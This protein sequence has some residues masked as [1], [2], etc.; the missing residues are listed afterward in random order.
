MQPITSCGALTERIRQWGFL[1]L[2]RN[3]IRGFSVEEWTPAELWFADGVD[4]P[5]EWKG[6]AILQSGCA[7]GKFFRGKAGFISREWYADF[8]NFRRDGYD[9]DAR[10]DDGLAAFQDKA[11]FDALNAHPSLL[12][13]D[14]KRLAGFGKDG[15]K[16]FDTV[17]TR[18]QMQGY[19]TTTN[20]EYQ[21]DRQGRVYGWGVGR[22]AVPERHF[23]AEF[24][25]HLY[26]RDPQGSRQRMLRHLAG[27]FPDADEKALARMVG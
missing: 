20:F 12:S 3:E 13:R 2:F 11:V 18:L 19:V 23:G 4:G 5:W 24:A 15:R 26:D 10:Y 14:L 6:P 25:A 16:G 27:L 21:V 1:P 7:Y 22:Y 8:A 9:F 17:I